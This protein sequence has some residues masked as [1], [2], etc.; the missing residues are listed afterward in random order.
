MGTTRV[1]LYT[2]PTECTGCE[3]VDTVLLLFRSESPR[4][5]LPVRRGPALGGRGEVGGMVDVGH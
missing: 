2:R 3:S 5:R 1:Y 4:L